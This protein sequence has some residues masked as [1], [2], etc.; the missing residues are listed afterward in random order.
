M[1]KDRNN[2]NFWNRYAKIYDIEIG[3]FNR[4]AYSEMYRLISGALTKEMKVLEIATG[5]G[6]I[7]INIA[8]SLQ[9]IVATD[10]SPKMIE[11]AMKKRAPDNVH[12]SV[13]N[14]TAL[15]F[16]DQT[17]DAVIISNALHIMPDP[18][19]VLKNIRRVLKPN[20]LLIAPTFSHGHLRDSTWKLN[21]FL[22]KMIGFETYSK[23]K[24]EEYVDFI[25]QNGFS[26]QTWKVLK[27]AFP[28]VYLEAKL[29]E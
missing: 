10:F 3:R 20:G 24:P 13:E 25:N 1:K 16:L 7:A 18:G 23:W 11:A 26:V 17:F 21:A 27:A 28:L 29:Q 2:K 9:S 14:A 15:S 19:V 6:L 4:S 8:D 5:T 22:L 12:F